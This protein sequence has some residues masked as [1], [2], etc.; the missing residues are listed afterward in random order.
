MSSK[1]RNLSA[2]VFLINLITKESTKD[3]NIM[4]NQAFARGYHASVP[5]N[6]LQTDGSG[7][8]VLTKGKRP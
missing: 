8:S 3:V 4:A 2:L 5:S 1:R 6:S 7:G